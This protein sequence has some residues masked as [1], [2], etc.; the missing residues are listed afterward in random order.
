MGLPQATSPLSPADYLAWESA[1]PT[2][3]EYFRGEVFAMGGASRRHVTIS[4]NLAAALMAGL[5]GTPC[6]VYALDMKLHVQESEA[7]FYPDVLVTCDA[8][9]HRADLAMTAPTLV[10][11]VLSPSTAAFDRGEKFAT[12]RRIP[13]LREFV[14]VDPEQRRIELYRR[15]AGDVWTL[16]DIAPG[17]Q[18]ILDSLS[19][20]VDWDRVFR[21]ID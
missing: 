4:L 8:R 17:A 5:D 19:T 1:Q 11:E 14:L 18:L 12:Y 3:S 20:R 10:I 2:K 13:S 15:G 7:Y 9:D 6:R 21:N 16:H